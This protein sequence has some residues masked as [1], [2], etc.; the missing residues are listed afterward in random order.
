MISDFGWHKKSVIG[1][2]WTILKRHEFLMRIFEELQSHIP[3]SAPC[4]TGE[5]LTLIL[6]SKIAP[7][8]YSSSFARSRR[9]GRVVLT[10]SVG[11]YATQVFV[12][13]PVQTAGAVRAWRLRGLPDGPLAPTET[14]GFVW[15]EKAGLGFWYNADT[16]LFLRPDGR[17]GQVTL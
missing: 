4:A 5:L 2:C 9:G 1:T 13:S 3:T 12:G 7:W 16:H 6:I 17:P 11:G 10:A 14:S 15:L 8:P